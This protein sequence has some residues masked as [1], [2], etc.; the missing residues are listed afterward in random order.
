[1]E[2]TFHLLIGN[3]NN[4]PPHTHKAMKMKNREKGEVIPGIPIT[5]ILYIKENI[6]LLFSF[7]LLLLFSN[8]DEKKVNLMDFTIVQ[9]MKI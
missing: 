1:M 6:F 8:T 9:T 4:P 7:I 3:K 5:R 2:K